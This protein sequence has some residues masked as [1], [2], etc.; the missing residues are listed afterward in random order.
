MAG[1]VLSVSAVAGNMATGG[2]HRNKTQEAK[3]V[4]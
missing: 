2:G 3:Q 1:L 4:K